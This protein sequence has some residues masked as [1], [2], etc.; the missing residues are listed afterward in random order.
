MRGEPKVGT[1]DRQQAV[2]AAV[3]RAAPSLA[4]IDAVVLVGS[5]ADEAADALSDIDLIVVVREGRFDDAWSA[6]HDLEATGALLAFDERPDPSREIGAHR[7]LTPDLVLVE[8]L[9]ATASSGV[10]LAPP[11]RILY[12]DAGVPDRLTRRD[13]IARAELGQRV[14]HPVETAY[15]ALKA[16]VRRA[17]AASGRGPVT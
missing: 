2:L 9:I 4:W 1:P 16:A 10:R 14:G 5:M 12:G 15:D 17:P 3:I 6:R 13:P 8:A 7:W 11:W